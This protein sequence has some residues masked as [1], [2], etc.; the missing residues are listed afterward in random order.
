MKNRKKKGLLSSI[1]KRDPSANSMFEI[2]L[3]YPGVHA[4]IGHRINHFYYKIGFKL[5][6]RIGSQMMRFFTG[7]EIHPGAV[8]GKRLFI[9]HG[10][11]VV[12]GETVVIG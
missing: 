11:G 7:I 3:C 10:Q 1:K 2:L 5:L 6:A 8:I 4:L 12:I 9:D